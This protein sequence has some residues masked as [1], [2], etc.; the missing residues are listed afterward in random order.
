MQKGWEK[1][2]R[3]CFAASNVRAWRRLASVFISISTPVTGD[4]KTPSSSHS[5]CAS[6]KRPL[7]IPNEVINNAEISADYRILRI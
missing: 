1:T 2:S 3:N 7:Q 4:A 6:F 5:F